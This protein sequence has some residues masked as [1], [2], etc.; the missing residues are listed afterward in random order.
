MKTDALVGWRTTI[1]LHHI[2]HSRCTAHNTRLHRVIGIPVIVFTTVVGS[3][4]F[5]TMG[6]ATDTWLVVATGFFSILAAVL[7]SLQ[8]FLNYST[9]AEKHKIAATH[10]GMLRREIEQFLDD[11]SGPQKLDSLEALNLGWVEGGIQHGEQ[12]G[13]QEESHE[14]I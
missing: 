6:K 7:S 2:A 14:R 1:R 3:T 13:D 11:Y 8:T 4:V 10:Y 12:H 5:G 9:L